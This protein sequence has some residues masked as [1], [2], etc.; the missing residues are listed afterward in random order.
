MRVLLDESLPRDLVAHLPGI[1][2]ATVQDQGWAGMQNGALL[3]AAREAGF[4]A[5]LTADRNVEHQQNVARS[6]LALIVLRA[7]SNRLPDL[8][9]LVPRLLAVLPGARIGQV[10]HVAG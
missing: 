7:R 5:L 1:D 2:V 4:T 6:G 3:Q 9:P 10:A 8:L